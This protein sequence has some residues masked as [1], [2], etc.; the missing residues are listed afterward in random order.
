MEKLG[1]RELRIEKLNKIK[2]LGIE[3]YP[4]SF[5][6][7]SSFSAIQ[8]KHG[9]L[10]PEEHNDTIYRVAG[11]IVLKRDMGK[12][13]FMT[14]Q[15]EDTTL[16]VVLF[17]N[18]IDEQTTKLVSLLDT[19]DIV[20]VEGTPFK[21]KKG[22]LSLQTT[23]VTLLC[24]SLRDL[25]EKYH[26]VKDTE[27]KYR[28]RSLDM[29]SNPESK[30]LL[31]K[32]FLML[33][34][35]REFMIKE[36]FLEVETPILQTVY[37]GAAAKPFTTYHN[38]LDRDFFLRVAI[39]LSLKRIMIGGMESIFEIGKT[40]RNESIDR[41]HNPE[42]S[43][44]EAYKAYV[45]YEYMMSLVERLTAFVAQEVLGTTTITF[46]GKQVDVKPPWQRVPVKDALN[47]AK[48]WDVDTMSDEALFAE[49]KKLDLDIQHHTRGEAILLL[50]EAYGE[51]VVDGPVHFI[52]YPK[53]STVFCKE[54]RGAP[55]L[56]ER[57]ES[58]VCGMELAN[59]YSELNDA[60]LQRELLE[61]QQQFRENNKGDTWGGLDA[62]FL[63]AMDLGL[64]PAGGVGIG[65]D[66]LF[67][68]L[69]GQDSIRDIL[70][71][72]AV[73]PKET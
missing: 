42:F 4:Y 27:I 40:F 13:K 23:S 5:P 59:A 29:I 19:G 21:T 22:E 36:Q 64:P 25:G 44:L 62:E 31:K 52:D 18:K 47:K 26:G 63:E 24:K 15:D 14:L 12:L 53:E 58:F 51:S 65:M 55:E 61:Q 30:H 68:I 7:N 71:F 46:K 38:M 37:G 43:M 1:I 33:Q 72:P 69:L 28:H 34:K 66:R 35:V 20:G 49:V 60:V 45:D 70:Y 39:E 50:F 9:Q 6:Y 57:F 73:K 10:Q 41:S 54:K 67:M 17:D 11:R 56:I 8:Q 3:P 32:R 2:E 48:N 16:Q